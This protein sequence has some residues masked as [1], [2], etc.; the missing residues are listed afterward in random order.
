MSNGSATFQITNARMP[1]YLIAINN[2]VV[3]RYT[4]GGGPLYKARF[5]NATT[6][7]RT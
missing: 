2:W 3:W 4:Y 5:L 1:G 6:S 7:A